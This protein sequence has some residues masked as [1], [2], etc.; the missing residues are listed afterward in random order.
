MSHTATFAEVLALLVENRVP[1]NE[2]VVLA[3]EASGDRRSLT[4]ARRMAD[5][6]VRGEP[7]TGSSAAAADGFPPLLTWLLMAGRQHDALLPAIRHAAETYRR[8][9]THQAELARVFLP[10]VLTIV[11]GGGTTLAYTLAMF[12]PYTSML[13]SL[14]GP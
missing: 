8:R 14:G 13:N 3:A 2:A 10:V 6:I 12:I 1:L 7:L 11:I 9:A 4:A 5:A